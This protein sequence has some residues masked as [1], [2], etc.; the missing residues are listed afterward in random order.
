LCK[1]QVRYLWAPE[2]C[3]STADHWLALRLLR[4]SRGVVHYV[5]SLL[6]WCGGSLSVLVNPVSG[7]KLACQETAWL[8]IAWRTVEEH[9]KGSWPVSVKSLGCWMAFGCASWVVH[10]WTGLMWWIRQLARAVLIFLAKSNVSNIRN[11]FCTSTIRSY[12]CGCPI[13]TAVQPLTVLHAPSSHWREAKYTALDC[14]CKKII[15][16]L[17]FL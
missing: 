13:A 1:K 4:K 7:D 15:K 3:S 16:K 6:K 2:W 12:Q 11:Y 10:V 5:Y 14:W 8:P 17:Q 9:G